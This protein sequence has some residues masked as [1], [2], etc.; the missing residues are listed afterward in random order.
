[1]LM[2]LDTMSL[3]QILLIAGVFALG[4]LLT[5]FWVWAMVDCARRVSAGETRLV[6]WLIAICLLQAIGAAVYVVFGRR[7]PIESG[8]PAPAT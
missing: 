6:G 1:M 3:F 4:L 8:Q 5:M 2:P 7:R